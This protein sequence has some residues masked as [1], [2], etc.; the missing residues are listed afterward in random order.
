MFLAPWFAIAGLLLAAGPV[1]IHLL[2]RQRYRVVD[3]AA[4]DFLRHAVRRSRRWLRLRDLVLMA[5]RTLCVVLFGLAM[6]RPFLARTTS[7]PVRTNRST[8]CSS[9]TIA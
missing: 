8:P 4:M 9:S 1:A 3:W 2:H 5:L 7:R 6:A